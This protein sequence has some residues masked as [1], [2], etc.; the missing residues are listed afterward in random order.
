[1]KKLLLI[2]S[3]LSGVLS[4]S[5]AQ[6]YEVIGPDPRGRVDVNQVRFGAYFAPNISWMKPTATKSDDGLFRVRSLGSK[7]GYTWGLLADYYFTYNYAIA[8]GFQLNT[9]GGRLRSD[10]IAKGSAPSTVETADFNYTLQYLEVPFQ[11]KLRSD[12]ITDMGVQLFGQIGVTAGVN[13]GKKATYTV[14][15]YDE[16]GS[17]QS[18]AEEREKLVGSFTVAP[19]LL[20][21]NIGGGIER[22]ISD[23]MSVYLGLFFNNGFLPDVTNPSDYDLGYMGSFGDGNIRQNSLAFRIGLFF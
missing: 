11:L 12:E 7:V 15:Y 8:T 19:F 5:F 23:R 16:N 17:Q 13:I 10:R 20:S 14:T 4:S 2:T 21:L 6:D 22:P 1:M 9:T 3:L 18:V